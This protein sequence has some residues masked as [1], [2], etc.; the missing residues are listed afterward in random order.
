MK[1]RDEFVLS[2]LLMCVRLK[3]ATMIQ[4]NLV[5]PMIPNNQVICF[6]A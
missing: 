4:I 6:L 5:N 3:V 2:F 1:F